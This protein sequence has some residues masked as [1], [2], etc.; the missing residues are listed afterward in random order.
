MRQ[1]ILKSLSKRPADRHASMHEFYADFT[2]G[3]TLPQ[4]RLPSVLPMAP[5]LIALAGAMAK[6]PSARPPALEVNPSARMPATEDELAPRAQRRSAPVALGE[7][8][9]ESDMRRAYFEN[10]APQIELRASAIS[11]PFDEP[12]RPTE[13]S[14]PR[15]GQAGTFVMAAAAEPAPIAP[16]RA[17]LTMP[18]LLPPTVRDPTEL[19][20]AGRPKLT[21]YLLMGA[22][23]LVLVGIGALSAWF[24]LSRPNAPSPSRPARVTRPVSTPTQQATQDPQLSATAVL[25]APDSAAPKPP[26][27]SA[28]EQA[29]Y[30]ADQGQC[31]LAKRSFASCT[32]ESPAYSA[33]QR[34][35]AGLCP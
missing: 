1:A 16:M 30:A 33:A 6:R 17:K 13:E 29:V 23:L 21:T 34:T 32:A 31:D 5:D 11:M 15:F 26:P 25:R 22:A 2:T 35:M 4:G 10:S 27:P 7:P 8:T 14:P 18:D 28:C 3:V 20:K 12:A 9:R 24:F 19:L